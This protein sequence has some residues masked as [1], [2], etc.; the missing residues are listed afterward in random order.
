MPQKYILVSAAFLLVISIA[1]AAGLP[2]R[3]TVQPIIQDES[4]VGFT[5]KGAMAPCTFNK[6]VGS[7]L[8]YS[9]G[10]V[11]GM[12]FV[13][14][15]NPIVTC[16]LNPYPVEIKSCALTLYSNFAGAT[17]PVTV[18]VI[19]YEMASATDSCAGP[20]V[21]KCRMTVTCD[22]ATFGFPSVGT[23]TFATPCCVK[24]PFY[25]GIQYNDPGHVGGFPSVLFDNLPAVICDNWANVQ[26][27]WYEWNNFWQPPT[28]GY[29]M[30]AFAAETNSA[31]C[32]CK[33]EPGDPH[34]MHFPQLPDE[35][36]WD[37]NATQPMILADDFMCSKTGWIK[38][39]H[40]WGSWKDG[41]ESPILSFFLS[42]HS[43]ISAGP[44]VPYSRPG[45]TL[46]EREIR[47]FNVTPFDPQTMEGWYDPATGEILYNNHQNYYRYDVC[48]DS[49][50]WFHQDSGIVYW[51]NISAV[52]ADQNTKWGWKS[53]QNRWNDDAVWA[54]WGNL[55]W[56]DIW[57]PQQPLVNPWSIAIDPSGNFVG[58]GG[59]GAYGNGW[60]FYPLENW[61]NIWFYDHPLALDRRKTGSITLNGGP[62]NPS[63]PSFLD[64]AV[65][66]STDQWAPLADTIPP[67][68]GVD[69]RAFIGRQILY[70]GPYQGG[71]IGP[72]PYIIPDYNPTWVSV[73]VR[74]Q[75][76]TID[77]QI[78]HECQPSL[79]LAFVITPGK[80]EPPEACC[81]PSGACVNLPPSQCLA[82]QGHPQ[83]P[84]SVCSAAQ[85]A[86]CLPGGGCVMLDPLCCVDQGGTPQGPGTQCTQ[87]QACCLPSGTCTMVDPLCCDEMGGIVSPYA[88]ACKGDVDGNGTDDA[89][90][91][92]KGACCLANGVCALLTQADCQSQ[93]GTYKGDGTKCLSDNN[94]NGVDDACDRPWQQGDPHKMHHPQ[95]PD[96]N[97]WDVW[98]PAIMADDWRCSESGPVKDIHF[99][100]SWMHGI[101]GKIATFI[102]RVHADIP[103]DQSPTGY[104][105]PAN[106]P[107]WEYATSNF[108]PTRLV[109][110]PPQTE[111]WY[112]PQTPLVIP[113]DH[114]PYV[115]Y[116]IYIPEQYWFN[117]EFGR[118]YWLSIQG[119]AEDQATRWGWKS[120]LQHF[121]DDAVWSPDPGP[122]PQAPWYELR[123]PP[124]FQQSLDLA[125][126]ITGGIVCDCKPGDANNDG[127]I[128]VGDAVYII[129]R[130]F[131][132]GPAPIPYAIC[133]GDANCD[134]TVNV[135]D[136]VFL[137]NHIFKQANAPCDC[138]TW[139]S[140]CG[141]PLRN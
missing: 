123:E 88:N 40:F 117:Q 69:E 141:L 55:N 120:S 99:W 29:P 139:L 127:N 58:G 85:E 113:G 82:Q 28:P 93:G 5:E 47:Q 59:G 14:Y 48:L 119:I 83:G 110:M 125:F 111:G 53:T 4:W 35:T 75:N 6:G 100:G 94:Q 37:V 42:L 97:G 39:I 115:Q 72:L 57:E 43:D 107:L 44:G 133:S 140:Q 27:I 103:A 67:L 20:G 46:W 56:V 34:K 80:V 62:M 71:P 36:G 74:G 130:V 32:I 50:D 138:R 63:L 26:A 52:V 12:A 70:S 108:N 122:N 106:P 87:T 1:L 105:M 136:A 102:F 76:F 126:V 11:N 79:N 135:A 9:G 54:T 10:I 104:S 24:G 96:L 49:I 78:M 17:W 60:Y 90:E 91:P 3:Q 65:N 16:G 121:N 132:G 21:E 61:W 128:N 33:W 89:C 124:L 13:T 51:L 30:F 66:W 25:A 45:Q 137:I 131:K 77:G 101:E 64:L 114:A 15:Y 68:P 2:E 84:G 19:I 95:L 118:I 7:P 116:D 98:D 134:C 31:N 38:D 22:Q 112:E 41:L 92:P 109:P 23:V 86:C 81:L 73:D 129:N 8:S 18:D